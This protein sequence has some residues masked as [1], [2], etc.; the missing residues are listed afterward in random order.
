M[1]IE[2]ITIGDELLKGQI[3]DTATMELQ[4]DRLR[5]LPGSSC[6]SESD[7]RAEQLLGE[8]LREKG[9]T[10]AT[11]ESC[12]GGYIAHLITSVPGAS[13]YFMGGVIT[14]DN[15]I[16]KKL[17]QVKKETLEEQG[18]VSSEVA[19]QMVRGVAAKM[20]TT[21]AI[22][23]TGIMGPDGGTGEKPVGTVW[24]ATLRG[25]ELLTRR[26]RVGHGRAQNIERTASL[27]ITQLLSMLQ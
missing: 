3:I 23:V 13:D 16:K 10:L 24:I 14:Y 8:L 1:K 11:A 6:L 18:A 12:T 19:E 20:E 27:G 22:A 4:G 9:L 5:E 15:S 25:E 17:L 26:Y 2:I 7:K 21:C